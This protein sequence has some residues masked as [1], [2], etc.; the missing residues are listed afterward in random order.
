MGCANESVE[1]TPVPTVPAL[2]CPNCELVDVSGVID[3]NTLSTSIGHIQ[4]Y[5]VYVLNQPEDCAIE[6]KE[7]LTKLAG[8]SIRIEPGPDD[9]VRNDSNHYYF[10]TADGVSIENSLIRDGLALAWSQDGKHV[11]WFLFQEAAA[12]EHDSGCLWHDYQAFQ[13]GE[14]NEFRIPGLTYRD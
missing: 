2:T 3:A 14:P 9:S 8:Q 5:G 1:P 6:A 11:G 7:Q 13:R 10:Y 12:K 4:M